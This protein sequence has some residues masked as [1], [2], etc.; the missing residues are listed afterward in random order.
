MAEFVDNF[1]LDSYNLILAEEIVPSFWGHFSPTQ[2][3]IKA[4]FD[5]FCSA[6]GKLYADVKVLSPC[7]EELARLR[8]ICSTHTTTYGE[9][10]VTGRGLFCLALR[11]TL[12]HPHH[13][14]WGE[15]CHRQRLVLSSIE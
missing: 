6:I 5:Q 15:N 14:L 2:D 7:L 12:Q 9:R 11:G 13:N 8:E 3:T 10:T 4:G 1:V